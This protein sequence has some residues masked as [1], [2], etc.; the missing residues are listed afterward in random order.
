MA[1]L[2]AV[3]RALDAGDRSMAAIALVQAELPPLPDAARAA[4]MAAADGIAKEFDPNEPRIPAGSGSESGEWTTDG[5]SGSPP[6]TGSVAASGEPTSANRAIHASGHGKRVAIVYS[7]GTIETRNGGSATWRTNNPGA[8]VAGRWATEHGA[9]GPDGHLAIFP[10]E[11]TGETAQRDL[12][13]ARHGSKTIDDMVHDWAPPSENDTE[14]YR[15]LVRLWT[16]LSGKERISE[17]TTEQIGRA[18]QAQRRM[19]GWW[20]GAVTRTQKA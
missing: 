18:M 2:A 12:L 20:S 15:R 9:I 11:A 4:R 17:L 3:A 5:D 13:V 8:I 14:N 6:A 16:G 10:D 7:D 19:E 1:K